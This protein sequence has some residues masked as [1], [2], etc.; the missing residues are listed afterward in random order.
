VT[1]HQPDGPA[2]DP[3]ATSGHHIGSLIPAAARSPDIIRQ[4]AV[5]GLLAGGCLGG[6]Y[7]FLVS[8]ALL[9]L[10]GVAS[11]LIWLIGL[12]IG[13]IAGLLIGTLIGVAQAL[14]R[15][16]RVP[17]P[18]IAEVV[19]ELTLLPLQ[20]MVA[21]KGLTLL[22]VI[23]VYAP[24]VLGVS[25]A[26]GL[27]SR[28]PPRKNTLHGTGGLA[29]HAGEPTSNSQPSGAT[30]LRLRAYQRGWRHRRAARRARLHSAR[31]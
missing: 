5:A 14:L 21:G 15:Q 18:V 24:S 22:P 9:F 11:A 30:G 25:I 12:V 23:F 10:L 20:L 4:W 1:A 19:T 16:T 17:A 3:S 13:G 26:A 2:P 8:L 31:R 6:G 27:G 7:A 28:L 29:L